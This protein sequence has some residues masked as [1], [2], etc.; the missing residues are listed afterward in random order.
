METP[1]MTNIGFIQPTQDF[2][3]VE[4]EA[5]RVRIQNEKILAEE[6][7]IAADKLKKEQAETKRI[8]DELQAKKDAELKVKKEEEEKVEKE[9]KEKQAADKKAAAA[10]DKEKLL[11]WT[12]KIIIPAIGELKSEKAINIYKQ[13]CQYLTNT[14]K[15]V[16][17]ETEKL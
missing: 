1:V 3:T 8:A 9:L 16:Q 5:E 11:A 15:Y 13:A 4:G 2:K 10:P 12:N 7:R 6:R 17:Q 14:C